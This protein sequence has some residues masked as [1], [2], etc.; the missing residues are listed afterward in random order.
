MSMNLGVEATRD[1]TVM[2]T[3]RQAKQTVNF[4]LWQTPTK[5]TYKIL[6][7]ESSEQYKLYREWIIEHSKD[8]PW[9]VCDDMGNVIG[10]TTYNAG[11]EH[12]KELDEWISEC[13]ADG[14]NIN[15][16]DI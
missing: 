10:E 7:G 2:K 6:S 9:D 5:V 8:V 11:L 1:I 3:G 14:Y 12:L 16:Y 4:S 13:E 15:W